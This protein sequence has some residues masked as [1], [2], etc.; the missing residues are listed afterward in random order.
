MDISLYNKLLYVP[1]NREHAVGK[2][3]A[4]LLTTEEFFS[5]CFVEPSNDEESPS[6]AV[7]REELKVRESTDESNPVFN[8]DTATKIPVRGIRQFSEWM[9]SND[10]YPF[11]IL[12]D[13][14]TG[15]STWLQYLKYSY[16]SEN[17]SFEI[18][19]VG[20]AQE[21]VSI[22]GNELIW[23]S[24]NS[25][26]YAKASS[27]LVKTILWRLNISQDQINANNGSDKCLD[28]IATLKEKYN[29]NLINRYPPNYVV[30]LFAIF[31]DKLRAAPI[32]DSEK[33]TKDH[34]A[35][36]EIGDKL[37][38]FFSKFAVGDMKKALKS[39]VTM[40]AF[41]IFL[42]EKEK[43]RIISF[44][45]LE[46]FIGKDQISCP[47]L[48]DFATQL[49][50]YIPSVNDA[51]ESLIGT[52]KVCVFM[53]R[54]T[55]RSFTSV[56]TVENL[57]HRI[58]INSWFSTGLILD[59]KFDWLEKIRSLTDS[60]RRAYRIISKIEK[61]IG[62]SKH[63][64][65]RAGIYSKLGMLFGENKRHI[66]HSLLE[67][68]EKNNEQWEIFEKFWDDSTR[69]SYEEMNLSRST[70]V[71]AARSILFQLILQEL[72]AEGFF[73][74]IGLEGGTSN[75]NL[76]SEFAR[77]LLSVLYNYSTDINIQGQNFYF[78]LSAC[79]EGVLGG[80]NF[81]QNAIL[82]DG[83]EY[84]K[85]MCELLYNMDYYSPRDNYWMQVIDINPN[86]ID[87]SFPHREEDQR[88]LTPVQ[89]KE[90]EKSIRDNYDNI[91]IKLTNTGIALLFYVINS[92][93]FFSCVVSRKNSAAELINK[94]GNIPPLFCTIPKME[95]MRAAD[96]ERM[97]GF[98][99]IKII[100][101]VFDEVKNTIDRIRGNIP[102]QIPS[103][104]EPDPVKRIIDYHCGYI[105]NFIGIIKDIY[106]YESIRETDQTLYEHMTNLFAIINR[107]QEF[108]LN[109]LQ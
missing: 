7:I 29:E 83:N 108:L 25:S 42:D 36:Y 4:N 14:G 78:P 58:L 46:R 39:L 16:G 20:Q 12:G 62:I 98:D 99:C 68:I 90:W 84:F 52:I 82:Q 92:F 56:Q 69:E 53:R 65:L 47:I 33:Q 66:T 19:D 35:V 88:D 87:F 60:D 94:Y 48:G 97:K 38:S 27:A 89:K 37:Y 96:E 67:A 18:V 59:K 72:F 30:S 1:F 28:K 44:D 45:G 2:D 32:E 24:F 81:G 54:T 71:F 64:V 73:Y 100:E 55:L 76:P 77:K 104:K 103:F 31:P 40:L 43:K 41:I 6:E 75:R 26:L 23:K 85:G 11:I 63:G 105:G 21:G 95:D 79:V 17:I 13:A 101:S 49:R 22:A 8:I 80:A 5:K 51:Y 10:R 9:N 86:N 70:A 102:I 34:K 57:P 91:Q 109:E 106:S 107:K 93:E 15:K 74:R 50:E 61:D 3:V